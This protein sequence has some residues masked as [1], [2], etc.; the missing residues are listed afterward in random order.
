[1]RLV[2]AGGRLL[3]LTAAAEQWNVPQGEL[4]TA[5]G[6]VTHARHQAHGDVRVA[7]VAGGERAAPE[8]AAAKAALKNPR[9]FKIIG[10]RIRSVDNLDIV[11]GRATFSIDVAPPNMLYAVF[12]KCPV[13]GGKCGRREPRRSQEAARRSARVRRRARGS[14]QQRLRLRRRDRG[15]QLVAGQRRPAHVAGDVG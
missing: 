14:G 10:K 2:G 4:S 12:E 9:D 1:M 3:M 11:T 8:T 15:R 7:G 13:F 5:R 6:V